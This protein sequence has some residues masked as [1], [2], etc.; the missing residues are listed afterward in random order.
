MKGQDLIGLPLR[1]PLSKYPVIY[2]LPMK[3]ISTTKVRGHM[4]NRIKVFTLLS[5]ATGVVTSVPSDA[6]DDF[7][8]LTDLK[9]N[10]ELLAKFNVKEEWVRPSSTLPMK[11]IQLLLR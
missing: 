5:Q 4:R 11:P 10:P 7:M 1:A 2:V 8:A 6:P 9:T 3:T